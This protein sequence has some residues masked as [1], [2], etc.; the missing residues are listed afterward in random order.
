MPSDEN[1]ENEWWSIGDED[2]GIR[3]RNLKE[4]SQR[5]GYGAR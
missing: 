5:N 2:C 3:D 4:Q 1:G